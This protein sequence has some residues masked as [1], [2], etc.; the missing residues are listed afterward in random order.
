MAQI[1]N[2]KTIFVLLIS[3]LV[4]SSAVAEKK[5]KVDEFKELNPSRF[6]QNSE[7]CF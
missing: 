7:Q 2:L 1:F 5:V 6:K 3:F 4:F